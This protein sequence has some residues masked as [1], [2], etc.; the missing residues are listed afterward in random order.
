MNQF[1]MFRIKEAR[2]AGKRNEASKIGIIFI[3]PIRQRSGME[4]EKM[5]VEETMSIV[6]EAEM[7]S[8]SSIP[9]SSSQRFD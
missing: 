2:T 1:G 9:R 8:F 7:R 3:L 6:Q 4:I 5:S